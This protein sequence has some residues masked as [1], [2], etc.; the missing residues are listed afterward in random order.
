MHINES[1]LQVG[2]KLVSKGFFK[3]CST[4]NGVEFLKKEGSC[5]VGQLLQ[6]T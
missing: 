5:V 2:K 3:P 1:I 6:T 4:G